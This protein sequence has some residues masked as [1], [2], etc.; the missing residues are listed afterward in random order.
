MTPVLVVP[1]VFIL[2]GGCRE[3]TRPSSP[4]SAQ[5]DVR[6]ATVRA[7]VVESYG[8]RHWFFGT[9][10]PQGTRVL[11]FERPGIVRTLPRRGARFP[12]GAVMA[13]LDGSQFVEQRNQVQARMDS[14]TDPTETALLQQE[15]AVLEKQLQAGSLV[16]PADGAVSR[17]LATVGN[18]VQPP[19]PILEFVPQG[20]PMVSLVVPAG[21]ADDVAGKELTCALAGVDLP[22]QMDA[23]A[24]KRLGEPDDHGAVRAQGKL[25]AKATELEWKYGQTVALVWDE[26]QSVEALA[27]PESALCRSA[28]DAWYVKRI[29]R[30]EDAL[31]IDYVAVEL[32]ACLDAW[33]LV[34]G[35]L[36]ANSE[37]VARGTHRVVRGQRVRPVDATAEEPLPERWQAV[38]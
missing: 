8:Q 6:V 25:D 28:A 21:V 7:R 31:T 23:V 17:V 27:L 10:Q 38:P 26:V 36:P 4:S 11:R 3:V 18:Q 35:T 37:V 15:L 13:E 32:V 16:A 1:L 12:S 20:P 24:P 19:S 29:N 33:C 30:D 5:R 14:S 34:T 2:V 9:L 22:C